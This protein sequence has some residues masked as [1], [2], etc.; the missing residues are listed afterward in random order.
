MIAL[1]VAGLVFIL[2]VGLSFL[3]SIAD[4]VD[5]RHDF[6]NHLIAPRSILTSGLLLAIAI[7]ATHWTLHSHWW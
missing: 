6:P 4:L 5:K 7:A 2:A 1:I 3:W